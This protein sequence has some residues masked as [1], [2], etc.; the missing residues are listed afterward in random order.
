MKRKNLKMF[1]QISFYIALAVVFLLPISILFTLNGLTV[2]LLLATVFG[3]PLS[4]VSMF[5]REN[6]AIRIFS[7]IV[8]FAPS[9]LFGYA[10]LMEVMDDLLRSPP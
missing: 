8:N 3:I 10:I 1:T 2:F 6:L 4:V 5:S 9:M 7:L